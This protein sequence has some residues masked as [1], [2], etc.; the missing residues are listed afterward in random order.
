MLSI[1]LGLMAQGSS[2]RAPEPFLVG[3]ANVNT[4]EPTIP[5][6]AVGDI[7]IAACSNATA[8]QA[9]PSGYTDWAPD[10]GTQSG[11]GMHLRLVYKV[12]ESVTETITWGASGTKPVWRWRNAARGVN[13][14]VY[15]A[16][17]EA[18]CAW[19]TL[20]LADPSRVCVT[21]NKGSAQTNIGVVEPAGVTWISSPSSYVVTKNTSAAALVRTSAGILETFAPSAGTFDSGTGGHVLCAYSMVAA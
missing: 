2:Y 3:F 7:I 19:P 15:A 18:S 21:A 17:G 13:S 6:G 10:A 8:L 9:V 14:F 12:A 16:T 4:G 20:T 11:T 5:D 1:S